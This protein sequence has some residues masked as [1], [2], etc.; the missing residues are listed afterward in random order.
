MKGF[1]SKTLSAVV[2]D[3]SCTKN[4]YGKIWMACYLETLNTDDAR[5]VE[6]KPSSTVFKFENEQQLKS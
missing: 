1:A 2:L 6:T 5:N 3:S 4:V